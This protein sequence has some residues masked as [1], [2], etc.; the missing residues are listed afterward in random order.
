MGPIDGHEG[1]S[2]QRLRCDE[3]AEENLHGSLHSTA[4]ALPL[5]VVVV[6]GFYGDRH[7]LAP[8]ARRIAAYGYHALAIDLPGHN[9]NYR[10][11]TMGAAAEAV[12]DAT[13]FLKEA[14]GAERVGVVGHS[15]GSLAA[16]FANARYTERLEEAF[17]AAAPHQ[18]RAWRR[19]TLAMERQDFDAARASLDEITERDEGLDQAIK[20]SAAT[21]QPR[22]AAEC[23]VYLSTPPEAKAAAS[24]LGLLHLLPEPQMR[25]FVD[26][27]LHRPLVRMMEREGTIGSFEPSTEPGALNFSRFH[28]TTPRAFLEYILGIREIG[29]HLSALERRGEETEL[30]ERIR[31]K[32]FATPKLFIY[33]ANDLLLRPYTAKRRK[34]IEEGYRRF[35]NATI[36]TE[37]TTHIMMAD[38]RQQF[39]TVNITDERII[40][41]AISF[42]HRH[43]ENRRAGSG[44]MPDDASTSPDDARQ[45]E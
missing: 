17:A 22:G 6:H 37:G 29:D 35:G 39:A 36:V 18:E 21:Y 24:G 13:S 14:V 10:P 4:G 28:T 41:Q 33:G 20:R 38:R 8:L 26:L 43:L 2:P 31:R 15:M 32:A 7:G 12:R 45:S 42:L 34:G 11:F 9:R 19:A 44:E 27:A 3:I 30:V 1:C 5:G 23:G 16:L 40:R 25:R